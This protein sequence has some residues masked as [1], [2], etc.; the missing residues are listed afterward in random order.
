MNFE[1][2]VFCEMGENYNQRKNYYMR[3]DC[4]IVVEMIAILYESSEQISI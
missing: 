3:K 1:S 4:L 2:V